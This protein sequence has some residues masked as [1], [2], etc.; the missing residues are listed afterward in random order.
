MSNS[1]DEYYW[2]VVHSKRNPIKSRNKESAYIFNAFVD[3]RE[4][5]LGL[6]RCHKGSGARGDN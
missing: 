1:H 2:C 5:N 4:N 6:V 3:L